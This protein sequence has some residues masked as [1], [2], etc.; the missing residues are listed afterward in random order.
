VADTT[1]TTKPAP[2]SSSFVPVTLPTSTT[3]A[4]VT[5]PVST[6]VVP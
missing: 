3:V 2:T 5:I 6:P 1:T 4:V